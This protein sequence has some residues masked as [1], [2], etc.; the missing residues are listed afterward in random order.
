M[1]MLLHVDEEEGRWEVE[2]SHDAFP[3][4]FPS[5]SHSRGPPTLSSMEPKQLCC[6]NCTNS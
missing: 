1:L 6:N 2:G 3:N 5:V 4:V